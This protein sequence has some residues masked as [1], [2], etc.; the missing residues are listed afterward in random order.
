VTDAS[1]SIE[2]DTFMAQ[3]A[4]GAEWQR[5]IVLLSGT[6]ISVVAIA[7]LYF[8]QSIFIPVALAIF[9]TFLLNP[10]VSWLRTLGFRRTPAVILTV[11]SAALALGLSGWIVTAQ[12]SSLLHE[13]PEHTETMKAKVKSLKQLAGGTG[14]IA[15]MIEDI[16]RELKGT[17]E[18]S[19]PGDSQS[20][21]QERPA[22]ER[23]AAVILQP[24]SPLWLERVTGFLSP[25]LEY[26][27][28]LALAI[29]LVI[30][31]LQ[32]R[33]EFRNRV[34]RLVGHGR[35]AAA[36]KF[37]DEAGHRISRFL[38]MQAIVNGS[39]GL[40]LG[41]GL[42]ALGVKYALLWGTLGAMLRYLPYIGAYLA[43][44]LPVTTTLALSDGWSTTLFVIGLFLILEL[45]V[46]NGVEPWLYGQSMGV[47]EI[48]LLVSAAFWAFLWGPIGLVLSSPLTVCLV[49]LGRYVPQLEFLAVLLGDEP[50]LAPTVS[51]YQRLL[52][53]DQD[54][55]EDLILERLKTDPRDQV[56]DTMLIPALRAAR[57]GKGR[58]EITEADEQAILQSISEIAEDLGDMLGGLREAG[59]EREIAESSAL[60]PSQR[61]FVV[62]GCPARD[63]AD[64]AALAMLEKLIDPTRWR[65]KLI[66]PQALSSELLEMVA[67]EEPDVVC[68]ASIPPGGRAHTRYLCK[69]LHA[70]FPD[71][72]IIVGRWGEEVGEQKKSDEFDQAG[73]YGTALTLLETRQHLH[74]LLPLLQPGHP[75]WPGP[76]TPD[77]RAAMK[78]GPSNSRGSLHRA[79]QKEVAAKS[80]L[81]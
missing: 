26:L 67:L 50:A 43:A 64:L 3:R 81:P 12:I 49:M 58:G 41:L 60:S 18:P 74:A 21:A 56:F 52:A 4:P 20:A 78:L 68:I 73:V 15:E 28:E 23:P 2:K 32:K 22:T 76:E 66:A 45:I 65:M 71:L 31:M 51:F 69:R 44:V 42:M 54:E 29:I 9:L 1:G 11:C 35:I 80:A 62:F 25:L 40:V 63:N 36:T 8:A 33:E 17:T 7:I 59:A 79:A 10:F 37:V 16:N 61:P 48:A 19:P 55:A 47:S 24:Q 39:F 13:L 30:F 5:A 53:R 57:E 77:P 38:L 14:R 6:V 75:D 34:I 46:A 72:R 27:G 70:R